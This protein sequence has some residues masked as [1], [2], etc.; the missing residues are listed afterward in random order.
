MSE[1]NNSIKI[2]EQS[3]QLKILFLMLFGAV[4]ISLLFIY[5]YYLWP[6][7]TAVIIYMAIKA[8]HEKLACKIK[9]RTLSSTIVVLSLFVLIMVPAFLLL[10]SIAEQAYQLYIIVQAKMQNGFLVSLQNNDYVIDILKYFNIEQEKFFAKLMEVIQATAGSTFAGITSLLT[11]PLNFMKSFFFMML[12]LFF[13]LKDGSNLDKLFYQILPFPDDMEKG[14]VDRLKS[15]IRIL[16]AGN[17]VVMVIQ[18]FMLGLGFYFVD[19]QMPLLWGSVAAILS[20]IPVVGTTFVWIPAVGYLVG[21]GRIE[22]AV[23]LA[24]WSFIWYFLLENLLKPKVF[25]DKL[26]FHPIIFFFLL[27]GSIKAFNLAGVIMG[28]ILLTLFYSLYE[29]YLILNE[30]WNL[31]NIKTIDD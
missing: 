9:N 21:A 31:N 22:A 11:V 17:F 4:I 1:E 25:G 3:K 24:I 20:L 14:V 29:I 6:F 7:V 12:M 30:D 23:F 15:V 26:K 16:L 5:R 19:I 2:V 13:L 28:P 27:L 18:G 10:A 8:L